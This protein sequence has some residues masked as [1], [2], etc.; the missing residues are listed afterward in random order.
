MGFTTLRLVNR[1]AE[2]AEALAET[3]EGRASALPWAE[4]SAALAGAA[5]LDNTTSLGMKGQPPLEIA[6]D[7]LPGDALVTDI[8]YTP[9]E[10]PLLAA[11]RT[12]GHATVDGLGMLLH[13]GRPGFHAWFG[14]DPEVT[15]ALRRVMLEP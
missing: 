7:R 6:L 1:T 14:V 12:R 11:A 8:V 5:L 4:R 10:T 2:R 13:Q 9:L 15:P 3:L